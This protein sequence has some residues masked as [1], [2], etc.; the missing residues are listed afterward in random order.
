M[1]QGSGCPPP[2]RAV[3]GRASSGPRPSSGWSSGSCSSWRRRSAWPPTCP[4][5]TCPLWC[6]NWAAEDF[7]AK[8]AAVE[9]IAATADPQAVAVLEAMVA[10]QLAVR[11]DDGRVVISEAHG[12]GLLL[13]DPL[14][15]ASLGNADRADVDPITVNNRL[16][17][18]RRP[19]A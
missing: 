10:G 3:V 16:T 14:T 12:G 4:P 19:R 15:Q 7:A 17:A 1:R 2:A 6:S 11:R 8:I 13:K 5:S 18:A 9:Q